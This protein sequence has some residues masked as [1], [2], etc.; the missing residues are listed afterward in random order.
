MRLVK[1]DG[2]Y[3][4]ECS[5]RDRDVPFSAG[6]TFSG[7][8][9]K[10][11]WKTTDPRKACRF[12]AL[13]DTQELHDELL[14]TF[15]S[16]EHNRRRS[17]I[18][19]PESY[20]NPVS[21]PGLEYLPFQKPCITEMVLRKR[22]LVADEMGLGK[23]I[24]TIGAINQIAVQKARMSPLGPLFHEKGRVHTLVLCPAT[25]KINWM[26]ELRKWL[27]FPA[28]IHLTNGTDCDVSKETVVVSWAMLHRLQ[29]VLTDEHWDVIIG[30]ECFPYDTLIHTDKGIL[31]IGYVVENRMDISVLSCNASTHALEYKQVTK[32]FDRPASSRMVRVNHQHGSLVCTANHRVHTEERGYVQAG[33]LQRNEHL[34][35]LRGSISAPAIP[36]EA[37]VLQHF[38]FG[39]V[40]SFTAGMEEE[41]QRVHEGPRFVEHREEK[42]RVSGENAQMQP[43][44]GI[45]EEDSGRISQ[46]AK[47]SSHLLEPRRKAGHYGA[48]A[49]SVRCSRGIVA[50]GVRV[51]DKRI[52]A[53]DQVS[54][55]VLFTGH[56]E[57]KVNDRRRG[58]RE[59]SPVSKAEGIG[60]APPNS[61]V[62]SRVDCVEILEQGGVG[63]PSRGNGPYRV[64][65]IEVSENHNYFA[66][67]T[68]V[69]N[70]HNV[71]NKKT[72]RAKAFAN[73][74]SEYGYLLSGT[75]ILNR[76]SELWTSLTWLDPEYWSNWYSF[77]TRYCGAKREYNRID[78]KGATNLAELNHRL[79]ST[80]MMRRE[81]LAVMKDL[82]PK[83]R[84]VI[85]LPCE[86]QT[87][88]LNEK[89]V[90]AE[91]VRANA[92][93]KALVAMSKATDNKEQFADDIRKLQVKVLLKFSELSKLRHQVAQYKLPD[94]LL[95]MEE[96]M[97]SGK[98]ALF[99]AYHRDI[100]E[101]IH[102]A[103]GKKSVI[104]Y[105][106]MTP[107]KKNESV[108]RFQTDPE[109]RL[110]S[111]SIK[112]A[113][114]G[115]TL[116]EAEMVVFGEEDWTPSV[117]SQC[118]D[119]AHRKGLQH[120]LLVQHVVLHGS[121]DA[122][123]VRKAMK[124]Q[125]VIDNATG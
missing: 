9:D 35:V 81:K 30:D 116:T 98:K 46:V 26:E 56:S 68:L 44:P 10:A 24:E 69:S 108:K 1:A 17:R 25:L 34:Q 90:W 45:Q 96:I 57:P 105:G 3:V 112:A 113:G 7:G 50:N 62:S 4:F 54:P 41:A 12:T 37:E 61:L 103:F 36:R 78:D 67:N 32:W 70:S 21:P 77:V 106:G 80:V 124:K 107:K 65:D 82:P 49:N 53:S 55:H 117:M 89:Q 75:P 104:L 119:R 118:E 94:L 60:Q 125:G 39:P 42:P 88:V 101:N 33:T 122:Y 93:L 76:P 99:F 120:N 85:E 114:F 51:F 115:L 79:R 19:E 109:V 40:E 102:E 43:R 28:D 8:K 14:V 22:M 91:A 18:P 121:L 100:I 123:M 38:V 6:F 15:L 47:R 72:L 27:V 2:V 58:G 97:T 95:H 31:P 111:G 13:A 92:R 87:L 63:G 29:S 66:S 110:F 5:H 84:Q 52:K 73:L 16:L 86:D 48:A 23:T 74:R 59:H 20:D 83:F 71:K 64:Y 11:S